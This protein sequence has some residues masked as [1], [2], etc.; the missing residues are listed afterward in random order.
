MY[1]SG[2][3]RHEPK[4]ISRPLSLER[5]SIALIQEGARDS[6]AVVRRVALSGVIELGLYKSIDHQIVQ[7]CTKDASA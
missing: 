2:L 7:R 3:R 5:S 4:I 1:L 6:S